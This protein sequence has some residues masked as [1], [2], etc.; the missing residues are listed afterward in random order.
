MH[1]GYHRPD[2]ANQR[3][4]PECERFDGMAVDGL[5]VLGADER[6]VDTG[7]FSDVQETY[8]FCHTLRSCR[9]DSAT[10]FSPADTPVD[11]LHYITVSGDRH[12]QRTDIRNV[13]SPCAWVSLFRST[14]SQHRGYGV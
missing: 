3:P 9:S 8:K 13:P 4:P 14:T 5:L 6:A 7:S 1:R 11:F 12:R 10:P 2:Q